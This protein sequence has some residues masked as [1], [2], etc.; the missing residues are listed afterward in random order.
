LAAL[1]F[2]A[3]PCHCGGGMENFPDCEELSL[4]QHIANGDASALH[5]LHKKTSGLLY[6]LALKIVS[7]T[8]EAEE[9]VQDVFMSVWKNAGKFDGRK[10]K[11]MTWM[12]VIM[13]NRC[14]DKIRARK[15]RIPACDIRDNENF[16]VAPVDAKTAVDAMQSKER[17]DL[18]RS[19]VHSLPAAQREVV[20]LAFFSDMTHVQ[21]A[22]SLGISLGTAKSRIRYAFEKMRSLMTAEKDDEGR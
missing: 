10:A 12:T 1:D 14:I 20:E 5:A 11:V 9:V 17:A 4:M 21:V 19:A 8:T 2:N 3:L 15:R 6:R 13:K 7:N 18:I 22:D 16:N